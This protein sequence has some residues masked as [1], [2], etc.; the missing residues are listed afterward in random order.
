MIKLSTLND[1][2]VFVNK[3][4]I[5]FTGY[6]FNKDSTDWISI[7]HPEDK[8][9]YLSF[10]NHSISE[11][12]SSSFKVRLRSKDYSYYW[13]EDFRKPIVDNYGNYIGFISSYLNLI[14]KDIN[15]TS[16]IDL[17]EEKKIQYSDLIHEF[18]NNLAV[19]SGMF[20]MHLDYFKAL[21][22]RIIFQ[23]FHLRVEAIALINHNAYVSGFL[24]KINF[25]VF[26]KE[27]VNKISNFYNDKKPLVSLNIDVQD[28]EL[29]LK[30]AMPCGLIINE[31]ITNVYRHSLDSV[32]E[33]DL[34][35]LFFRKN[36]NYILTISDNGKGVSDTDILINPKSLGYI[37][38]NALVRQLKGKLT[39]STEKGLL[40]QMTF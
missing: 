9:N 32:A 35:I 1:N 15:L 4:W 27:L 38:I 30:D 34:S 2:C 21:D 5:D 16:D 36:S 7:I 14:D 19:I 12:K 10:I 28:I 39:I 29:E 33:V 37:L 25:D 23:S 18:K 24:S 11:K 26:S 3:Q 13:F 31:L 20:D 22:E 40:I 6:D 8:L 17:L